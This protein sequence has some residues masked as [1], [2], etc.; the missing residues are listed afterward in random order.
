[1]DD[2]KFGTR[3]K[4]GDWAPQAHAE[5]PPYWAWPPKILS[6]LKWLPEYLFPWNAFHMATALLYWYYVVPDV[7]TMKTLGLGLGALALCGER[8]CHLRHVWL[9]RAL[10]LRQAQTGDAFQVQRQVSVGQSV[11]CILVQEP[12]PRQLPAHYPLRHSHVDACRSAHAV[13][14]RQWLGAMAELGGQSRTISRCSSS[15]PR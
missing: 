10:L 6:V 3:N 7:E 11:G 12:E 13:V 14:F 9:D 2:L 8:H 15:S 5:L 1:M 4:R